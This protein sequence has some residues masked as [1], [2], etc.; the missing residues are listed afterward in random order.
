M[1]KILCLVLL[2]VFLVSCSLVEFPEDATG[3]FKWGFKKEASQVGVP[4]LGDQYGAESSGRCEPTSELMCDGNNILRRFECE[5]GP[6]RWRHDRTCDWFTR[7]E[8]GVGHAHLDEGCAEN[9]GEIMCRDECPV[10]TE[11]ICERDRQRPEVALVYCGDRGMGPG[12]PSRRATIGG[13]S[14]GCDPGTGRL[15]VYQCD[16]GR[17]GRMTELVRSDNFLCPNGCNSE[18]TGCCWPHNC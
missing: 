16:F 13:E 12:L 17:D 3:E 1:K 14:S 15:F 2:S 5:N 10:E 9:G 18:L 11:L 6:A 7:F 4:S 8:A